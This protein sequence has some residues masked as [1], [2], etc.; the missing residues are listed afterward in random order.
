MS[1]HMYDEPLS[2][3]LLLLMLKAMSGGID[4]GEVRV[5]Y[6]YKIIL[7][8]YIIILLYYLLLTRAISGAQIKEKIESREAQRIAIKQPLPKAPSPPN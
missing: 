7:Y 3:L 6:Y 8:Y 2:S 4:Q 1:Y 5:A